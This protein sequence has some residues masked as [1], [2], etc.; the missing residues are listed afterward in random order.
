M[1]YPKH[2][3][4][5]PIAEAA[6][7]VTVTQNAALDEEGAL[8][9][10]GASVGRDFPEC[11]PVKQFETSFDMATETSSTVHRQLG[12]IY[13]NESKTRAVQAR[14]DGFT[15]NHVGAYQSLEVLLEQA[16]RW[17]AVYLDAASPQT[18]TRC[19]LRFVNRIEIQ[20]ARDLS[21]YLR[22][23][24]EVA[25]GLPQSLDE[26][27]LRLGIPFPSGERA[28]IAQAVERPNEP[29]ETIALILDIDVFVNVDLLPNDNRVWATFERLRA[30]KNQCF[31]ESLQPERWEDFQ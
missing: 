9:V 22:T 29:G 21:Y 27:S 25:P 17:W 5:A 28:V 12:N 19:G 15:L 3:K 13:W 30:I 8:R 24:A 7:S 20:G 4:N 26:Y 2:L 10:F 31:F 6:L 11:R 1:T 16:R 18:V 23:I 14:R